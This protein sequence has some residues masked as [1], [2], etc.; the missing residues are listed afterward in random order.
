MSFASSDLSAT[1][2]H[3][4]SIQSSTLHR[5]SSSPSRATVSSSAGLS[6]VLHQTLPLPA[7]ATILDISNDRF[8]KSTGHNSPLL[9]SRASSSSANYRRP[10]ASRGAGASPVLPPNE[11]ED[12]DDNNNI[13]DEI[14]PI[15]G[16]FA[17]QQYFQ[18]IPLRP[19]TFHRSGMDVSADRSPAASVAMTTTPL[20]G[21]AAAAAAD[22]RGNGSSLTASL[23]RKR[24]RHL[25]PPLHPQRTQRLRTLIWVTRWEWGTMLIFQRKMI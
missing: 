13:N 8:S 6:D 24:S 12:D 3:L 1:S 18:D 19:L 9:A 25:P 10:A 15:L 4:A 21:R 22:G 5:S 11:T 20:T 7:P 2:V 17:K 16:S 14:S 23:L